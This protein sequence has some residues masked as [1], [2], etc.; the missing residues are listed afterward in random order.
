M[1]KNNTHKI[2]KNIVAFLGLAIFFSLT[3]C[4]EDLT[5]ANQNK[6]KNFLLELPIMPTLPEWILVW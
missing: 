3:S 1:F 2:Y 4:E 5:K 6:N